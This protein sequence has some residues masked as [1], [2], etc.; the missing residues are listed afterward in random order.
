LALKKT[1]KSRHFRHIKTFRP[2]GQTLRPSPCPA[3]PE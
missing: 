2:K 1:E 3:M